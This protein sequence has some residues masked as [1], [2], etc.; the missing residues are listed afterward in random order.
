[1]G[2]KGRLALP[3][4][5]VAPFLETGIG[6]SIGSLRTLTPDE[7]RERKGLAFHIPFAIGLAIGPEH[8]FEIAFGYYFHPAVKQFDGAVAFG[9]SFPLSKSWN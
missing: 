3:I 8:R 9:I 2:A 7:D 6:V 5:W 4:P 1:V